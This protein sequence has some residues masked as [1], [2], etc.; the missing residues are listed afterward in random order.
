MSCSDHYILMTAIRG[1]GRRVT[2]TSDLVIPPDHQ[3]TFKDAL[4]VLST[5]LV[6][7]IILPNWAKY[8][9]KHTRAVDLAFTEI[10]VRYFKSF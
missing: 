1:F 10:K 6:L 2:W 5:N 8:L 4:H 9:T 3:M 7:K